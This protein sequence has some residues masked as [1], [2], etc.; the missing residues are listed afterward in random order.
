MTEYTSLAFRR[1]QGVHKGQLFL[2]R[3]VQVHLD[4][5]FPVD[6]AGIPVADGGDYGLIRHHQESCAVWP[7][8]RMELLYRGKSMM[9]PAM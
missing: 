4:T 1:Q 3:A 2:F 6:S 9:V 8:I 7:E 5:K